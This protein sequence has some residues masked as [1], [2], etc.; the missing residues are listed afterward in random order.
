MKDQVEVEIKIL[1]DGDEIVGLW[2]NRILVKH[3]DGCA[4]FFILEIDN[5]G[6]PRLN[7]KTWKVTKGDGEI[8]ITKK[9]QSG[10]N[11]IKSGKPPK[12]ITF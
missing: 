3:K 1:K 4:E 8:H 2:E 12:V 6:H 9:E 11:Q 10:K 7:N 5:N